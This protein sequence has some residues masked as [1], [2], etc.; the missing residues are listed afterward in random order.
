MQYLL[1]VRAAPGDDL[2]DL[3]RYVRT[4]AGSIPVLV[5][6]GSPPDVFARNAALFAPARHVP[7]DPSV[8]CRNGKVAGVLTGFALTDEELVLVAD[9]DV[10]W[11]PAQL[12]RLRQLMLGADAVVPQN[13]Y[14]PLPWFAVHDTARILINRALPSG[15]FP[16]T[17]CVRLSERLRR[18]GYD[19]DVLFEN[20]ELV[21]TVRADGGRVVVARDLFVRRLP[22]TRSHFLGQRVRQAYDSFAQPSR[23]VIEAALL[24]AALVGLRRPRV[25]AWLAAAATALAAAGRCRCGGPVYFPRRAV[26]LAPMWALERAVC[27]WLAAGRRLTGGMPYAGSRLRRAGTSVA[28]LRRERQ[29]SSCEVAQSSPTSR[30]GVAWAASTRH[31]RSAT[32]PQPLLR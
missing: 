2:E 8:A 31:Q 18:L 32:R 10:R 23:A 6:D 19:G 28:R 17:I 30:W 16:G 25:L 7:P 20:L 4:L 13:Y 22:P 1:P 27:F 11:E 26:L 9:D 21:R 12:V 15:D 29:A 14:D 3:G 24:P 5:V